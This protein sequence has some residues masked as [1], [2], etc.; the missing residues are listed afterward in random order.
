MYILDNF[1]NFVEADGRAVAVPIRFDLSNDPVMLEKTLN[2]IDG[3]LLP[4]GGLSTKVY[5]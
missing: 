4:G 5:N 3:V 2:S 1:K